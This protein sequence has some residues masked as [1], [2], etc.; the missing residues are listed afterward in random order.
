M[1][2][3]I[4]TSKKSFHMTFDE[5]LEMIENIIKIAVTENYKRNITVG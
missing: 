2:Q 5:T 1:K 4:Y 3:L